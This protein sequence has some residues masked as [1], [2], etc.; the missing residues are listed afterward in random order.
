MS[1]IPAPRL[2]SQPDR[3]SDV[4]VIGAGIGGLAAAAKLSCEGHKVLVLEQHHQPGG[5]AHSFLRRVRGQDTVYDFDVSMHQLG[6]LTPG[7]PF[8][9]MLDSL[10]VLPRLALRR[11][12]LAY[13]TVGPQHDLLVPAARERYRQRLTEAFPAQ[14]RGIHDLFQHVHEIGELVDGRLSAAA[15]DSRSLTLDQFVRQHV[16]DDRLVNIFGI[17][18]G[19]LGTPS[20]QLA[21]LPFAQMWNSYH[22]G[23]CTYVVGGGSALVAALIATIRG[24]GGEV[25]LRHSVERIVTTA[26]RVVGVQTRRHGEFHAPVVVCNTAPHVAFDQLLD[27]PELARRSAHAANTQTVGASYVQAYVGVRGAVPQLER[28]RL[29]TGQY[30]PVAE[31]DAVCGADFGLQFVA[32]ANHTRADP[33]HVP[34]G[35]SILHAT[36]VSTGARWLAMGDDEYRDAKQALQRHLV[37]RLSQAVPDLKDRLEVCETGT[38]RTMR[39]YTGN[40]EGAVF[41]YFSSLD[42]HTL[43]RPKPKTTVPGLFLTG[44]WTFPMG[45]YQGAFTSGFNTARLVHQHISAATSLCA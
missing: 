15:M 8:H 37:D 20:H 16:R 30:D 19:Y 11:F 10:G 39:R 42:G 6:D 41:G 33:S 9:A 22:V 40:P 3:H 7:R 23:G 24:H 12:H 45:G 31:W 1:V 25:L 18:S 44:A 43:L 2:D 17:L 38:P 4:I 29:V 36:M 32:L 27:Q 21:V 34:P 5:Y 28:L 35:R 13:R 14:A 26:G